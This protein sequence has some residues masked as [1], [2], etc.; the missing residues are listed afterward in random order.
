MKHLAYFRLGQHRDAPRLWLEGRRL[1]DVGAVPG[2]HFTMEADA[3]SRSLTIV[4]AEHGTRKVS[5]KPD[6]RPVIDVNT[7]ELATILGTVSRIKATFEPGRITITIHPDDG[8]AEERLARLQRK[9]CSGAVLQVGSVFHGCGIL[10]HALHE[11]LS[12]A[13]VK[14]ELAFAIEIESRFLETSLRNNPVWRNPQALAICG[15]ADE[16]EVQSLPKVDVLVAGIPCTGASLSGRAKRGL[17]H[18]ESHPTAGHLFVS[19]LAIVRA[20]QPAVVVIENVPPYQSTPSMDVIRSCLGVLGYEISETILDGNALGSLESRKRM[21]AVAVTRGLQFS[22]DDLAP[23]RAKEPTFGEV[24]DPNADGWS[25]MAH[26]KEKER[27]DHARYAEVGHGTGFKMQVIDA[28]S[29]SVPVIGKDYHK[30]RSTEPKCRHPTNPEL[31]RQLTPAEHAAV[32]GI[33]FFL[34]DGEVPTLKHQMLGQ[35]VVHPA[36]VAVGAHLG[37]QLRSAASKV[38]QKAIKA[39][40]AVTPRHITAPEAG[41]PAF[42]T[43]AIMG[44][45]EQLVLL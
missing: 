9:L 45:P 38:V 37:K 23:V 6:G 17:A 14:S 27:R 30:V 13:G 5:G 19:F 11:G 25:T 41:R 21:C 2:T 24:L 3:I 39:F 43:P 7:R 36:F 22:W 32:K 18:A 35:S 15:S 20:S 42:R 26:L 8:A 16:V 12:M 44:R 40:V 4:M 1:S 34:V 31:L 28:G 33:P 10:D 29:P